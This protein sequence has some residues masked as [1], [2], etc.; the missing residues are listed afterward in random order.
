MLSSQWLSI[1]D[2]S[3]YTKSGLLT[4][5]A[6]LS[7]VLGWLAPVIIKIK[8]LFDKNQF[9]SIVS[10]SNHNKKEMFEEN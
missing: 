1:N 8:I 10:T 7:D 9:K 6:K 5:A 2:K 3:V 4:E